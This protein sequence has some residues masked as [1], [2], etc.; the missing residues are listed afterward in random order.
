V[1][2]KPQP[3]VVQIGPSAT[4]RR[5]ACQFRERGQADSPLLGRTQWNGHSNGNG[6]PANAPSAEKAAEAV[7]GAKHPVQFRRFNGN[8][9][10]GLSFFW[11]PLTPGRPE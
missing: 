2:K 11:R 7:A 9:L 4:S 10:R 6:A 8:P 1:L 5:R 3:T